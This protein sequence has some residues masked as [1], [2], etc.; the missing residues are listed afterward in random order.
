M[1]QKIIKCNDVI[2]FNIVS[3]SL[4]FSSKILNN[5]KIRIN[6]IIEIGS[7]INDVFVLN[8]ILQKVEDDFSSSEG[9]L[10]SENCML[11]LFS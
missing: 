7:K 4:N 6:T 1:K 3:F 10:F 2:N 11:S 8:Q 5:I 9:A